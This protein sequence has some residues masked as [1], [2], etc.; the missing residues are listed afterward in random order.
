MVTEENIGQRLE[1]FEQ[2]A[3]TDAV[4]ADMTVQAAR[5]FVYSFELTDEW[6]ANTQA[7]YVDYLRQHQGHEPSYLLLGIRESIALR[8]HSQSRL[9]TVYRAEYDIGATQPVRETFMSIEILKVARLSFCA[10]A[11]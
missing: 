7:M 3:I 11:A 5:R 4:T 6:L 10:F 8:R 2:E 9:M 1:C